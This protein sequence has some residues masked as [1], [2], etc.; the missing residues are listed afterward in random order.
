MDV[1]KYKAI[2]GKHIAWTI[3]RLDISNLDSGI[4]ESCEEQTMPSWSAFN[5]LV[6]DENIT[7]RNNRIPAGFAI[8]CNRIYNSLHCLE[9]F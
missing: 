8:P 5:S 1:S 2:R 3:S 6:T 9:K 4:N 7:I